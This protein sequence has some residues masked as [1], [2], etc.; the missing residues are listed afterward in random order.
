MHSVT[1]RWACLS[2]N[3]FR[4]CN[5]DQRQQTVLNLSLIFSKFWILFIF[6]RD[7]VSEYLI[8]FSALMMKSSVHVVN[9]LELVWLKGSCISFKMWESCYNSTD[10][11]SAYQGSCHVLAFKFQLLS[12]CTWN[13]YFLFVW[14]F[15]FHAN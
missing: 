14:N 11:L 7:L 13:R 2:W 4:V 5:E 9:N 3:G 6:C 15:Y 12:F 1:W 10:I 8:Y